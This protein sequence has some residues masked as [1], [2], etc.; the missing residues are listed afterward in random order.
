MDPTGGTVYGHPIVIAGRLP[1]ERRPDEAVVDEELASRRHLAVGSSWRVGLYT[2]A[3]L[4]Q[5][6]G[7]SVTPPAGPPVTLSIVGIVR[8]PGDVLPTV[9][10]EDSLLLNYG[11]L[12]LTPAFWRRYGPD[13]AG[14]GVISAVVVRRGPADL[15]PTA[16]TGVRLAVEPGRGR[17][18]VP[19]RTAILSAAAAVC[20]VTAAGVFAASLAR[21][22]A[23]PAAYG[24]T[25][26]VS[27][28]NFTTFP[29]VRRA[30]KV[31]NATPRSTATPG[32]TSAPCWST[33]PPWTPWGWRPARTRC[34]CACWTV[35]SPPD[36]ARSRSGPPPSARSA[37]ASATRS[38]SRSR[39]TSQPSGSGWSVG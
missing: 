27:V 16:V 38:R 3:Q 28:G 34:R 20:A 9:T 11:E 33:A 29:E 35:T 23:T 25:W 26:D 8:H 22:V 21:L 37:S 1:D 30:A 24:W 31:L 10:D 5:I 19:V 6:G 4:D 18:A 2:T 32:S 14:H 15:P 36:P 12:Y 7:E 39:R 17:T 13:L